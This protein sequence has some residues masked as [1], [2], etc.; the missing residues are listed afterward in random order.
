MRRII[1]ML[2]AGLLFVQTFT[3]NT[4]AA[5]FSYENKKIYIMGDSLMDCGSIND[6][7]NVETILESKGAEVVA[8]ASQFG[9]VVGNVPYSEAYY[10][11][12]NFYNQFQ[13]IKNA[14]PEN[15]YD[16]NTMVFLDGGTND[17]VQYYIENQLGPYD[18]FD[19]TLWENNGSDRDL[20]TSIRGILEGVISSVGNDDPKQGYQV[21]IIF[22]A[23]SA[24]QEDRLLRY[25]GKEYADY[26]AKSLSRE[27]QIVS[28][29]AKYG[30]I[31]VDPREAQMTSGDYVDAIHYNM[32]GY[33]KI[34][35]LID[36]KLICE[37]K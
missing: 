19:E 25:G 24:L 35:D 23:P 5:T 32:K 21:P 3:T 4:F 11:K 14:I 33:V 34:F 26:M 9:D 28:Q 12:K 27:K 13:E 10:R 16:E 30:V 37:R 31:A 20:E 18:Y 17:L 1:V 2:L 29:Y 36:E 7:Q 15:G 6:G 22:L 8:N